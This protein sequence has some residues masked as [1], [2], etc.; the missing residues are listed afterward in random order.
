M[1]SISIIGRITALISFVLGNTLFALFINL[2]DHIIPVIV[3][4]KFIIVSI[5]VNLI[6]FIA[7]FIIMIFDS[8]NRFENLKTCGILLLNIPI[9]K[10]Y[11]YLIILIK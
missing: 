2:G 7:N 9:A 1:Y 5:I 8:R 10:L 4:F 11:F 3:G 6:L